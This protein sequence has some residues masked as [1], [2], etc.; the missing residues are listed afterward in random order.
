MEE[1]RNNTQDILA[2]VRFTGHQ[3]KIWRKDY[4]MTSNKLKQEIT[5]GQRQDS[6]VD[7]FVQAAISGY[8]KYLLTPGFYLEKESWKI[9][10]RKG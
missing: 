1:N 9:R 3:L 2:I 4:E 5:T 7:I 6:F 8:E 10:I